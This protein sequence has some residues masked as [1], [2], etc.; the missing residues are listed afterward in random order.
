LQLRRLLLRDEVPADV[1]HPRPGE[2]P[3]PETN[4]DLEV[5]GVA[6]GDRRRQ[7]GTDAIKLIKTVFN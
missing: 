3:E 1:G 4:P 5:G 2:A 6:G 7:P